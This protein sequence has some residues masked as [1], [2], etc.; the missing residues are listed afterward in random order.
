MCALP[1]RVESR[2]IKC[3]QG[4]CGRNEHA[5]GAICARFCRPLNAARVRQV[6]LVIA[7]VLTAMQQSRLEARAHGAATLRR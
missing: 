3:V 2:H 7:R 1:A 6:R 5:G 4:G